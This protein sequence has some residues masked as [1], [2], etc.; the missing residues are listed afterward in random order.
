[1][2]AVL[3]A[4]VLFPT[5]LREIL[6]QT[7]GGDVYT[8][9][10]SPRILAEW[11]HAAHKLGPMQADRAGAEAALLRLRCPAAMVE[12]SGHE[13]SLGIH[14]PDPGDLH[15]VQTAL[16][17]DARLIITMNLRD[18]PRRALEPIGLRAI[19]PDEFLVGALP[20]H[21]TII[22]RA[23]DDTLERAIAAGGDETVK[24][25][26]RR[27]RLPRLARALAALAGRD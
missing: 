21:G 7:A 26:L 19:H 2:K 3:D 6:I 22:R 18:F 23:V 11:V 4:N 14:L 9:L 10:W 8:P 16:D 20:A 24:T 27:A 17:S 1:M 13:G 15:V 12:G 5:V 25:L